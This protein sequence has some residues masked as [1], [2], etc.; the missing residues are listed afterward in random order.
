MI[1]DNLEEYNKKRDFS[2]TK[3]PHGSKGKR[4]GSSFVVQ[5][6][7]A[8]RE[9][10][11]L[12]LEWQ[13]VMKSFAVP[14]GPSFDPKDKRLAVKVEDHPISYNKFEGTIPKGEYGAGTVILW[15]NGTW[16]PL[17]K[18]VDF[19]RGPIKF[20]LS[21]KRL[22]GIWNLVKLKDDDNWILIK[23][24]DEYAGKVDI[25]KFKTSIK[26]GKTREEMEDVSSVVLTSPEKIIYPK[27]KITKEE[28]FLYYKKVLPRMLPYIE[29]RLISTIRCP[30]GLSK[31]KF[32]MKHLN[33]TSKNLGKKRMIDKDGAYK[34]Y[35]Y[36]KNSFGLLEEVQMNSFE[37]HIWGSRQ[38]DVKHP[39]MIVFDLDPDIGLSLEKVR[40]GV[41]N[42]KSILDK[43]GLKS[44]LKTSGGK[45]YHVVVPF[46]FKSFKEAET[47]SSEVVHIMIEKWP[48]RYTVNMR[49]EARRGKIFLDY[50]RNKRGATS[51]APYSVRLRDGAGISMPIKWG[52]LE[53]IK[54]NEITIKTIDKY[55]KRKDPWEQFWD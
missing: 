28:I 36:I 47:I 30:G 53:R 17:E 41:K 5:H 8:R 27:D 39:D 7:Y 4:K 9:H 54:P 38:D 21:G 35:F 19:K 18:D 32:F 50:Y 23:E 45:G 49:K 25:T 1:M 33:T 42:L 29:N 2:K 6:H 16:R 12:R 43:L 51:V 15:D 22:K 3:E 40:Q 14:R 20:E 31:E 48:D 34:D 24:R 55:L 46:R 11:D 37:F 26:S 44:F 10:Y 13:G 52:D